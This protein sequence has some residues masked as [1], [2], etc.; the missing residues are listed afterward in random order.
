MSAVFSAETVPL[1]T[2]RCQSDRVPS[3][4]DDPPCL[5]K[6]FPR[7]SGIGQELERTHPKLY[8]SVARQLSITLTSD[9]FQARRGEESQQH[10]SRFCSLSSRQDEHKYQRLF[11]PRRCRPIR[12]L[13]M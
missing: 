3:E 8:N 9:K 5:P 7:V 11:L 2:T 1:L 4:G 10:A 13:F 12:Y 6:V